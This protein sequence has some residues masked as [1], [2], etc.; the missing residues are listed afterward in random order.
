MAEGGVR[1]V[2]SRDGPRERIR[3]ELF[4]RAGDDNELRNLLDE[5]PERAARLRAAALEYLDGSAA[6]WDEAPT[7]EI[8]EMQLNQL[9]ALGYK[10]R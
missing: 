10:V 4:D 2:Y 8:D 7:L 9:R 5:Q 1:Y 6:A 3:E